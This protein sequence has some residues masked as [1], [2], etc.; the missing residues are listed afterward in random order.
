MILSRNLE[1]AGL[2]DTIV[3]KTP[4]AFIKTDFDNS[5]LPTDTD[6]STQIKRVYCELYMVQTVEVE[7]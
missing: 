7:T 3:F 2:D 1:Y 4:S 6:K 5:I